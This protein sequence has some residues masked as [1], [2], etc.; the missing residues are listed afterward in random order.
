MREHDPLNWSIPLPW[1]IA[2]ITVRVHIVFLC[3][4]IGVVLWVATAKQFAAGLWPQACIVL[5][6]LFLAVLAHEFGHVLAARQT[7][8]DAQELVLWPL[9]GLAQLDLAHTPRAHLRAA[10]GGPLVS[11]SIAILTGGVLV[12]FGFVPPMNPLSSPLNP[13]LYSW[14]NR[15]WHGSVT[16]PNDPSMYY[17][18]DPATNQYKQ[19]EIILDRQK[20][21]T[22]R[23]RESQP[24]VELG[25]TR[26][27]PVLFL[28]DQKN[29]RVDQA[30]LSRW[31]I[32]LAQVFAVNW[33]LFCVNL[34][35]AF[36]FDA[37]RVLQA[38][39]W[40]HGDY[41]PATATIAYIGFLV[42]LVVGIYAIAVN[43]LLPAIVAVVVYLQC[44]QQLEHLAQTEE[45]AAEGY[46]FSAPY[47]STE[48]EQAPPKPKPP[49]WFQ[50]WQQKRAERRLQRELERRDA[51]ERRLDELLEKIHQHG[52]QA[53]TPEELRFLT[54]VSAERK[55][56]SQQG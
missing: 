48:Q 49:T 38:A 26:E 27:S 10:F 33:L 18:L 23:I 2:G 50:R 13:K 6:L 54:R 22:F 30:R 5:A 12:G 25:G 24:V 3:V 51:E 14:K 11:L 37:A 41:R 53:L 39:L 52:K 45:P 19:V 15:F 20:D 35:P 44:R 34:L 9:G 40:R 55:N 42:M 47:G 1:R 17:Y 21:G 36:P 16:N 32:V 56:S 46:D 29:V 43:D 8:G 28:R 7:G 4:A 31:I